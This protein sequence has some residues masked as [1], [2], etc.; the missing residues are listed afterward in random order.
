MIRNKARSARLRVQFCST[1]E[2]LCI[3][4]R[5]GYCSFTGYCPRMWFEGQI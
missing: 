4:Y 2:Y 5:N 3:Y 1:G